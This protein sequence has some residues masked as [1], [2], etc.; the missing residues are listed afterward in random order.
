MPKVHIG[1]AGPPDKPLCLTLDCAERPK[2]K[3][4]CDRCYRTAKRLVDAGKAT[5]ESLAELGLASEDGAEDKF[6]RA[7]KKLTKEQ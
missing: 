1:S 5:W 7:F 4:L 2:W 3:G 6:T